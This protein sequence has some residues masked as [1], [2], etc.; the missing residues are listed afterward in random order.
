MLAVTKRL[1]RGLVGESVLP[2]PGPGEAG[3]PRDRGG[4]RIFVVEAEQRLLAYTGES[5]ISDKLR[6][7]VVTRLSDEGLVIELFDT[8]EASLFRDETADPAPLLR[9][10]IAIVDVEIAERSVEV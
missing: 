4:Q 6:R 10:L 2:E 5:D 9:D 8:D 1:Q 7:H 3:Q